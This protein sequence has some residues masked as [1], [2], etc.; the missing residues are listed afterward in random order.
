MHRLDRVYGRGGWHQHDIDFFPHARCE[1]AQCLQTGCRRKQIGGGILRGRADDLPY[2]RVNVV[3]MLFEKG[4]NSGQAF[5]HPWSFIQQRSRLRKN[6]ELHN[7]ALPAEHRELIRR[8][9][10][11]GLR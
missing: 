8:A 9:R 6:R 5:G 11:G 7:G 1:F 10:K 2:H 4:T 3:G